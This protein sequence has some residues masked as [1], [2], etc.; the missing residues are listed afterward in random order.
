MAQSYSQSQLS[1]ADAWAEVSR[2]ADFGQQYPVAFP[3]DAATMPPS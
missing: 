1:Q 2:S 3:A